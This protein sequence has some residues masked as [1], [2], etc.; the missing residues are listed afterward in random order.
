MA[1]ITKS[2]T[3]YISC[4]ED[5][6]LL[7]TFDKLLKSKNHETEK[8]TIYGSNQLLLNQ[9]SNIFKEHKLKFKQNEHDTIDIEIKEFFKIDWKDSIIYKSLTTIDKYRL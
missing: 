1:Q 3:T 7:N 5:D 2:L 8:I 4:F 6:A 9:I